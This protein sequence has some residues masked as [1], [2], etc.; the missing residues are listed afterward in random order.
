MNS[1][2]LVFEVSDQIRGRGRLV[3][4]RD[5]DWF[6]PPSLVP[7]NFNRPVPSPSR[8]AIPVEGADFNS[9][10]WRFERDGAVEGDA[11]IDGRWLES[12]ISVTYQSPKLSADPA[13]R[14]SDPPC[15]AP[16]AGWPR[17]P[18]E[19]VLTNLYFDL[20]DLQETG[21]AVNVVIFRP[22]PDQTLLVVAADDIAAVETRLRPQLADRLCVTASCWTRKQLDGANEH[23]QARREQ[24]GIYETNIS[25]DEQAQATVI[26]KLVRITDEIASWADN[27]PA[28]LITLKPCLIPAGTEKYEV[29]R[30]DQRQ[31]PPTRL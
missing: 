11:T 20:G 1:R 16:P 7:L 23:L 9:I 14:W 5:G 10:G 22:S 24:W 4:T 27:Q 21:A 26:T 28:G 6:E 29:P 13:P 17:G 15:P 12:R 3:R 30:T 2:S 18:A 19:D 31:T 8:Y 25:S